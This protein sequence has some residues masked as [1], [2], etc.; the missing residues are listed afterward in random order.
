MAEKE[1]RNFAIRDKDS[2]EIGI[3]TGKQP[4]QAGFEGCEF[5]HKTH[6]VGVI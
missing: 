2:N 6:P 5:G 4:R 3:V 1:M